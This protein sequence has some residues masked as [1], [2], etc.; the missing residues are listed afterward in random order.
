MQVVPHYTS[1]WYPSCWKTWFWN[2]Y[3]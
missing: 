3:L 1:L 2:P